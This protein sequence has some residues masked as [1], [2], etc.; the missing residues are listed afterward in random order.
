MPDNKERVKMRIPQSILKKVDEYKEENGL[1]TRTAT[2]LELIRKGL[3][4]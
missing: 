2:I 4:K 1:S 3:I